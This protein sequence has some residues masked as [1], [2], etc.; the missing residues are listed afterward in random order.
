LFCEH[1]APLTRALVYDPL[2]EPFAE[3]MSGSCWWPD[4]TSREWCINCVWDMR[5]VFYFRYCMTVGE[6]IDHP[7]RERLAR[8]AW[9][10][11]EREFPEWPLFRPERRSPEIADK[12]RRLVN[13]ANR[14]ACIE[15]ERME[16]EFRQR[17]A[18]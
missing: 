18:E 17:E 10:R 11:L 13:R 5:A 14:R 15:L 9:E 1:C 4:E 6:P 8:E 7:S 2:A 3:L 12:V 16:R